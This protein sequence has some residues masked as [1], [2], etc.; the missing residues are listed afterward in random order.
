MTQ[1]SNI[2]AIDNYNKSREKLSHLKLSSYTA[3]W[4]SDS[5]DT[6]IQTKMHRCFDHITQFFFPA[7]RKQ[8]QQQELKLDWGLC[9]MPQTRPAL[10][11]Q[12]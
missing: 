6:V 3:D 4:W 2:K 12:D 7:I 11:A 9:T 1:K 5:E 8:A 10:S